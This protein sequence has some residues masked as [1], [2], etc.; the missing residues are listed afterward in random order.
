MTLS[1]VEGS[2]IENL[3]AIEYLTHLHYEEIAADKDIPLSIDEV[4]Y[5]HL[6][7]SGQLFSLFAYERSVLIGYSINFLAR[8][9]HYSSLVYA[10]NDV[11]F[12][13]AD[14]RM[15]RTGTKLI[16]ATEKLAK[17]RGA[18][19]MLWHAKGNTSLRAILPL[20]GYRERE[21]VMS[22]RLTEPS[23]S[24]RE[25]EVLKAKVMVSPEKGKDWHENHLAEWEARRAERV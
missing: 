21:V 7:S 24:A 1:I 25:D 4:A 13:H 14:Y 12:V 2:L 19:M 22:R 10:Q 6:E 20:M 15:G 16:R 3:S 18:A 11:I 17:K 5:R 8:H 23:T 9:L